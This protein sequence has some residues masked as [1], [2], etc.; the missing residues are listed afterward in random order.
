MKNATEEKL[1]D[2]HQR[3]GK[4]IRRRQYSTYLR[5][6]NSSQFERKNYSASKKFERVLEALGGMFRLRKG[7]SKFVKIGEGFDHNWTLISVG[8]L[9]RTE[10][11]EVE[12]V[13][14][15]REIL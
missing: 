1:Y 4:E 6:K 8:G 10:T 9:F 12:Y 14:V 7:Q 11:G 13:I 3:K 5:E 2:F 15:P